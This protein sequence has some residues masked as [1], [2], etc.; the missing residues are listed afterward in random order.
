MADPVTGLPEEERELP[1]EP[2]GP[3]LRLLRRHDFRNLFLAISASEL[4]DSLHYIALMWV[5]LQTGGPL[6]VIAVRLA[7]SVP[8]LLF[9][10]HGGLAADRR[11]R[12]SADGR[13]RPRPRGDARADRDRW[14]VRA[15]AALGARGRRVLPRSGDE[16]LRAGIR[17][18]RPLAGRSSERPTGERARPGVR[19]GDLDR[20]LGARRRPAR[21]SPDLGV[22]RDQRRLI[23]RLCPHDPPRPPARRDGEATGGGEHPQRFRG[24]AA[25]AC[26]RGRPGR[27]WPRGDDLGGNLD[28]RRPDADPR[29]SAPRRRRLL[30]R[31]DRLRARR[32]RERG[33]SRAQTGAAQGARR[34]RAPGCSTS[35]PTR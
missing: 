34:H 18:T 1:L 8:A 28:R 23:L 12:R 10:L 24:I 4:G 17:R 21:R 3:A 31:D 25:E 2:P 16:L 19:A 20:R 26:A 29:P 11:D 27:A 32:D 22:L 5:A 14:P 15:P 7:D 13:R 35:L 30:A 9:G 6:G 33:L